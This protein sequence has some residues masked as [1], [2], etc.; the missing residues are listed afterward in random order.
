MKKLI[1]K[2]CKKIEAEKRIKILFAV[3]NGSRAWRM[4]SKNSDYDVRFVYMR[5]LK[6]YLTINPSDGV[7]T[8]SY[9]AEGKPMQQEGC[10]IDIEGFDIFKFGKLLAASNPTIIE[11]LMSDI[12]Y[13]GDRSKIFT[14][15]AKTQ[16]KAISLYYHYGSICRQNYL[17]YIK[18]RNHVTYK[19]Y[20]YAMRGLINA[21]Y[22]K[23]FN[24]VPP[25][26]FNQTIADTNIS[27]HI[28]KK[29]RDIISLKKSGKEKDIENVISDF[30]DYIESFLKTMQEEA[31][32]NQPR[33][34]VNAINEEIQKLLFKRKV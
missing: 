7:I 32:N 4:D 3:E 24:K 30:D 33:Q 20:L 23:Q 19:K 18:T 26:D 27:L 1:Y 21:L 10:T 17:K 25:I 28:R 22:V 13:Y 9:D 16:F 11:W 5:P 29:L 8:K 34:T 12:I 31:P 15:Y 14:E 6:D 2:L